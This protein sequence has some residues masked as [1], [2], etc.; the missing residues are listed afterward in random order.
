MAQSSRAMRA[1]HESLL[2]GAAGG[3][4]LSWA[5]RVQAC[6]QGFCRGSFNVRSNGSVKGSIEGS[7][8]GT[9]EG[10][11]QGSFEGS[12][13]GSVNVC[14][15]VCFLLGPYMIFGTVWVAVVL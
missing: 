8:K 15:C 6:L 5:C 1:V 2:T 9:R 7:F 3:P 4:T 12:F 13:Q 10:S 11:F 14:V